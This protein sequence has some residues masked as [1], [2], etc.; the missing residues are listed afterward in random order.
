MIKVREAVFE[1]FE[2]ICTLIGRNYI[3]ARKRSL[4][5]WYHLWKNN[6]EYLTREQSWPIGW[7][8]ENNRKEIVG[9]L[10][11]IPVP[12]EFNGKKIIAAVSSSWTTDKEYRNYSTLLLKSY[13]N[14]SNCDLFLTTTANYIS[15]NI[16]PIFGSKKIPVTSY[17]I[18]FFWIIK[19]RKFF[20]SALKK[21]GFPFG[22]I[23]SVPLSLFFHSLDLL[24]GSHIKKC[25]IKIHSVT[26]IDERF[27][28]FWKHLR[29][30]EN[31]LI[32]IRDSRYLNWHL[33]YAGNEN[34]LWIYLH[35]SGSGI[36]SYALFI[37]Q[38]SPEIGLKRVYLADFQT[39]DDDYNILA[40]MIS[41]GIQRCREEGIHMLEIVGFN[42]QKKKTVMKLSPHKRKLDSWPFFYK[43]NNSLLAERL[44]NP[45]IWDPCLLDGDSSL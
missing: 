34:R 36:T 43:V 4:Y 18:S 39:L 11:N 14:Q 32:Q 7:V 21:K 1:D 13:F 2:E 6:H 42:H 33:K 23:I 29:K 45:D 15:E 3:G 16:L 19:Y 41:C 28:E 10:G 35:K 27:D 38:D 20:L 37:R 25:N 44:E 24:K 40:G 5:E 17:D 30:Q 12:Y 31:Y 26:E 22:N 8:L 9:F